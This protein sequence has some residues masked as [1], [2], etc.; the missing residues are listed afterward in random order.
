MSTQNR[1]EKDWLDDMALNEPWI[2]RYAFDEVADIPDILAQ[3]EKAGVETLTVDGGDGTAGLVF[4]GLLNNGPYST[5]PALALLPSGKTNMTAEA[6]SLGGNRRTALSA[7]LKRH[8]DNALGHYLNKQA[9]VTLRDD[10][11]P[12]PR[13]GAF[14]GGADVVDGILYCRRAIYP[15]GLPNAMSHTAALFVLLWRALHGGKNSGT[16][17]A[18]FDDTALGEDGRFFVVLATTMERVLLGLRPDP[19]DGDGP[20]N[21]MSLRPG[22]WPVISTVPG[23]L[24]RRISPSPARTVRRMKTVTISSAG[25]YTLDGELY[26][27][28]PEHPL[29]L[30]SHQSLPFVQW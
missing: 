21:Y 15:L 23:L 29:H 28:R 8:R 18:A 26:E 14:F 10:N 12:M 9:V 6:W 30:S 16:V 27:T 7:L 13:H 3:C 11:D 4:S 1:A 22:T 24:R 20:L 2:R 17:T 25:Q 5:L 19:L